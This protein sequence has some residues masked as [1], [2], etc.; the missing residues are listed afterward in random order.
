[1]A[2]LTLVVGGVRSGKSRHAEQLAAA[3]PPVTYLATAQAG[4]AEMSRRIAAHRQR[5]PSSWFTIEEPWDI[6]EVVSRHCEG[7]L[8]IECL[9]L[10]LT[11]RLVGLADRT[12]Q[13]DAGVRAAV[14]NLVMGIGT[15]AGSIIVV[16]NEVGSGIM[17]LNELARRFADLLGEANQQLAAAAHEVFWCVAGIPVRIKGMSDG[18]P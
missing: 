14:D 2:R 3:V 12:A 15:A 10:W 18:S 4:D 17:P 11:N 13:N 9:S 1:M 16:S 5:R 7:S 6:A 8:L